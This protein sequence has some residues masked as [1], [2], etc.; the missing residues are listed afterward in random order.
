MVILL[1][2]H[3]LLCPSCG[4]VQASSA[5]ERAKCLSCNRSWTLSQNDMSIGV[6]GSYWRPAEA[7]AHVRRAKEGRATYGTEVGVLCAGAA[8]V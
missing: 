3:A 2:H 7:G 5:K 8:K 6:L 1:K 4:Q